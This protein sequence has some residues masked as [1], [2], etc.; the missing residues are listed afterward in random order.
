[1]LALSFLTVLAISTAQAEAPAASPV[2]SQDPA[3]HSPPISPDQN[4]EAGQLDDVVVV[5]ERESRLTRRYVETIR[6]P[7]GN[8]QLATWR[9]KLCISVA[10]LPTATAQYMIDRI[11]GVALELGVEPGEPGCAANVL[12]VATDD[13]PGVASALVAEHHRAFRPGAGGTTLSLSALEAFT[14]S[15]RPVRWWHVSVPTDSESGARAVRFPGEEPATVHVSRASRLRSDIRDDL[16]KVIIV[17]DV[18]QLGATTFDRLTDYVSLITLAQV[19]ARS[20]TS[21][22]P[23]VLN[24]FDDPSGHPGL[25]NWDRAYLQALYNAEPGRTSANAQAGDLARLMV[26]SQ[27]EAPR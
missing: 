24:I 6:A 13:G 27:A 14:T 26:R 12:I 16:N 10:N 20:D 17:I 9:G 15:D 11:S 19:D 2:S 21:G 4:Q 25:S 7:A 5:G 22:L 8:R 18:D 3:T 23:T 1:M